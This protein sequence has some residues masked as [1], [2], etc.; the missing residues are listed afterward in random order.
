MP[1]GNH[2][3][4]RLRFAL[5]HGLC[6]QEI[7][8]DHVRFGGEAWCQDL[9]AVLPAVSSSSVL[10]FD[11]LADWSSSTGAPLALDAS[12]K[13]QGAASLR[14]GPVSWTSIRSREFSP[15]LLTGVTSRLALDVFVPQLSPE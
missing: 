9:P 13:T 14:F 6:G 10:T 12:V 4:A 1:P 5:N 2:P 15:A 11:H 3:H 8:V 7:A